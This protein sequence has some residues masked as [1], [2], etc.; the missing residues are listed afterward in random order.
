M[1]AGFVKAISADEIAVGGMKAVILEGQE[2]VVCN[3]NGTFFAIER[4]CGHMNAPLEL[5][6]LDGTIVTCPM[7]CAQFGLLTGAALC[8]PMPRAPGSP[9]P[10]P[11]AAQMM[12]HLELMIHEA[13]TLPIRTFETKLEAGSVWVRLPPTS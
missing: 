3:S 7:H 13:R 2:L 9:P 6:T 12:H 5:G 10:T 11:R 1:T 4:R 8:G